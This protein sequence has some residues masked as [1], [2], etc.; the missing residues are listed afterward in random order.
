MHLVGDRAPTHAVT[1]LDHRKHGPRALVGPQVKTPHVPDEAA[2]L[3]CDVV[4][5]GLGKACRIR[6]RPQR[7][8][9]GDLRLAVTP[10]LCGDRHN[11]GIGYIDR[12]A[13]FQIDC[14]K[15]AFDRAGPN[16][17][18]RRLGVAR[19]FQETLALFFLAAEISGGKRQAEHLTG[20]ETALRQ[21][22]HHAR[23]RKRHVGR[24]NHLA[25]QQGRFAG[26]RLPCGHAAG[27][28]VDGC[29]MHRPRLAHHGNGAP[30]QARARPPH[31]YRGLLGFVE[32]D[33]VKA[34]LRPELAFCLENGLDLAKFGAGQ[35]VERMRGLR[36]LCRTGEW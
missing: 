13:G 36:L 7:A 6:F 1:R 10:G 24:A 14:R 34:R 29:L 15:Q 32:I 8:V 31:G 9:R 17:G 3:H 18:A 21:G 11:A 20:R 27:R 12:L 26:H 30:R 25:K 33:A 4:P 2:F 35:C 5:G 23:I 16:I 28:Q 22:L 19:H